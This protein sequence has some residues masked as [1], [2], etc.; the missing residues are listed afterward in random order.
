MTPM[1]YCFAKDH[2]E[3]ADVILNH[4]KSKSKINLETADSKGRTLLHL[5][6]ENGNFT[7]WSLLTGREDCQLYVRDDLGNTPLMAAAR[8]KQ[9]GMLTSW[10]AK[11]KNRNTNLMLMTAQ[12]NQGL[13]LFILVLLHLEDNVIKKF[14]E[15]IDLTCCID[16]VDSNG[17]NALLHAAS[18]GKWEIIR[19]ILTDT[20]L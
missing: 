20:K 10:L 3:V 7:F 2:I 1:M 19:N 13:N 5:V 18:L 17:N 11:Q 15:N 6:A 16:Q 9:N 12:N 14:I 4:P 8:S